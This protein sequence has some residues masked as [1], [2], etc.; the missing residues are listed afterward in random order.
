VASTDQRTTQLIGEHFARR[1]GGVGMAPFSEEV[2]TRLD[3]YETGA[4]QILL[5]R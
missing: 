1:S 5:L 3:P 2:R 4:V